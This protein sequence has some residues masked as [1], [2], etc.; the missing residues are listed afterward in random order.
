MKSACVL[1]FTEPSASKLAKIAD[2]DPYFKDLEV[3]K[4]IF[5]GLTIPDPAR[6]K[7]IYVDK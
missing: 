2:G 6:P 1:A 7:P 5:E 4:P 3:F